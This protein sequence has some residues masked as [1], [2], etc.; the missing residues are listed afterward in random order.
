M[1]HRDTVFFKI[2]LQTLVMSHSV[3]FKSNP[4]PPM[5]QSDPDRILSD[6]IGIYKI[7]WDPIGS[8]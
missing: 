1:I 4:G 3:N 5:P 8:Q 6:P 7:R 2:L